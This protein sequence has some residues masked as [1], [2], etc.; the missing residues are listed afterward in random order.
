MRTT[1]QITEYGSFISGKSVPGY[2]T[3]PEST[4]S[5]L[6]AFIL[7]NRSRTADA[8]D[9]L[10]LSAKKGL[11]KVITSRNYVGIITMKDG[12][13][14]EILPKVYS[15][16]AYTE[17]MVKRL[18]IDMLKSLRNTPYKALQTS[19][20]N[21]E[22]MSVFE[23]F[24][25]MFIEE[26]FGI[27]KRG[28]RQSYE[29]VEDN[30][31]ELKGKLL[32]SEQIKRNY[33]HKERCYVEFDDYN[34]N[35]P[36]NKLI[37]ATLQYLNMQ[38]QSSL[39]RR[40]IKTLMSAF[41]EIETS[42]D[43]DSDFQKC[44]FDRNMR[45]YCTALLWCKVFL[46]GKSFTSFS[47]SEVALALLFPMETLFESYIAAKLKKALGTSEY[48]VTAQD[49]T[50][51]LFDYPYS[52]FLMKPDI[53]VRRKSDNTT[54]I[55]D[56]KWKVLSSGK[57]N[58]GISQSDM[59]QMYAYHKKYT[60]ASTSLLYPKAEALQSDTPIEFRSKDEV[61]VK[62]R[63]IDLF[64]LD[65]SLMMLKNELSIWTGNPAE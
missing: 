24:V 44:S 4:F 25:R 3:L 23:V 46:S 9:F 15:S 59:Y 39:N 40:D 56:T 48:T 8:L 63:Q 22:K 58:F 62:I 45:D 31:G 14:I 42:A 21:I 54:F 5:Q 35:R 26:A 36:E 41:A 13:S 51:H 38:S 65:E 17:L 16:E 12:V 27:V 53:V 10:S 6:E 7:S 61:R 43:Y 60:A 18:L 29:A 32:F 19:T 20:V 57:P 47:G 37:K 55:F 2:V 34:C 52:K 49:R 33:A 11:G 30:C 64:K 50:Y 1:Y 28:L